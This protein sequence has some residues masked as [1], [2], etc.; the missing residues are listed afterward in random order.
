MIVA[1]HAGCR[2]NELC[3]LRLEPVEPDRLEIA[4]SKT[5]VGIRKIPIRKDIQQ[6]IERL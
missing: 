5:N 6:I 2:L 3:D 4:K 1:A